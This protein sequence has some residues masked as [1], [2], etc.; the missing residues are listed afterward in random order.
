MFIVSDRDKLLE[1]MPEK[2][3]TGVVIKTH[4]LLM[5]AEYIYQILTLLEVDIPSLHFH[6]NGVI[7][8]IRFR[9]VLT[10]VASVASTPVHS[11]THSN[12]RK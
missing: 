8:S 3:S 1:L 11:R 10:T 7:L 4:I 9:N 2:F 6:P 5:K 12:H